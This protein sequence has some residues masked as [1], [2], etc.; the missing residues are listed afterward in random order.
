MFDQIKFESMIVRIRSGDQLA[1]EELV[2]H[3]EPLI[4][5]EARLQIRDHRLLRLFDSQDICQSVLASFFARTALGEYDLET[6]ENLVKLLAIMTRNKVATAT[7][8]QHRKR[9]DSRRNQGLDQMQSVVSETPSPSET[10]SSRELLEQF[11]A[12]FSDE[13]RSLANL[14]RDGHSWAQIAVQLGGTHQSRRMQ[15][16]RAIDRISRQIGIDEPDA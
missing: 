9:R 12:R 13:E 11:L 6:P 7:Q 15:L 10:V 2:L 3:Y 5:R 4:R 8:R 16:S 1:A 14:R